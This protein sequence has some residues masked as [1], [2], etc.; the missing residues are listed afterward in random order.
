MQT[1]TI[2]KRQFK[3]SNFTSFLTDS[4]FNK[5]A[6]EKWFDNN[7]FFYIEENLFINNNDITIKAIPLSIAK[8]LQSKEDLLELN[9]KPYL[10]EITRINNEHM[11]EE[12]DEQIYLQSEYASDNFEDNDITYICW[13][14]KNGYLEIIGECKYNVI[15]KVKIQGV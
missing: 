13:I 2:N 9:N 3:E 8:K 1:L 11:I 5:P 4:A 14:Y 12:I 6:W 15:E 10:D 7:D